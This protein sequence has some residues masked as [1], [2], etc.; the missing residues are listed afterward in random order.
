MPAKPT[1]EGP[2][3]GVL[4][5]RSQPDQLTSGTVRMRQNWQTTGQGKLRRGTGFAKF[6]SNAGYNNED[7]HDQLGVFTNA[8]RSPVTLVLEGESTRRIRS[9]IVGNQSTLAQLD[10][11]SGNY[12]ILKSGFGGTPSTSAN[13]PR[14]KAAKL[15]DYVVFTNNFDAPQYMVMEQAPDGSGD[16]AFPIPELDVIGLSKAYIVWEWRSVIF[17]ANVVMDQERVSYRLIWSDF[18]NPLGWDPATQGTISGF[19]DLYTYEEILA[20]APAGNSFLIYTTHGIWEMVAVGGDQ[21]FDFRRVYNG[22][23]DDVKAVLAYPNT[24]CNLHDAH[25]YIG[26]DGIYFFNQYYSKPERPEWLH[27]GSADLLDNID[28]TLCD[29]H[30]AAPF[31]DEVLFSVARKG[32]VNQCPDYT[33]RANKTYE[34]VDIVD[35]GFVSFCQYSPQ[36]TPTIRDFIIENGICT[37]SGLAEQ[38]YPFGKQGLP[39]PLTWPAPAFI[40]DCIHTKTRL[41]VPVLQWVQLT[42]DVTPGGPFKYWVQQS[43]DVFVEDYTVVPND[44]T[45]LC[46]LLGDSDLTELCRDCK[47]VPVFVAVSSV[48]WCLKQLGGVFYR[49]MCLNPTATGT[50]TSDGYTSP[51]GSYELDPITSIMRFAPPEQMQELK[52]RLDE[53]RQRLSR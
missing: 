45:S 9:L 20:G 51:P 48:D 26:H 21:S 12:K 37:L 34:D 18:D 44:S 8:A 42:D 5:L 47:G 19:K 16:Y 31:G 38:G 46:A 30:V 40:P 36:D 28:P 1:L 43:V 2:L 27:R 49:E 22:E 29:A 33:L 52:G 35:H 3:T 10:Q 17:F 53:D 11:H 15:G 41:T 25:T 24:L 32:A 6:L 14:F 13:A 39:A 23:K 7:F 50:T 4:D